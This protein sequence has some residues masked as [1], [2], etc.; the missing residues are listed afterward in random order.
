MVFA[1]ERLAET[2]P[3]KHGGE[4]CLGVIRRPRSMSVRV[5]AAQAQ[6]R[7]RFGQGVFHLTFERISG[8]D[9]QKIWLCGAMA[10]EITKAL[11]LFAE[12]ARPTALAENTCTR[13]GSAAV[14]ARGDNRNLATVVGA[15]SIDPSQLEG[16]TINVRNIEVGS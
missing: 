4:S 2:Q 11:K 8:S 10:M 1:L 14:K 13:L 9:E 6:P 12:V 16:A 7:N 3:R 5:P 15:T